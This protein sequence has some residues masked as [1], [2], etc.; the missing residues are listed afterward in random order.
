[1]PRIP[2]DRN[3]DLW[4]LALGRKMFGGQSNDT[5]AKIF[6]LNNGRRDQSTSTRPKHANRQDHLSG[7]EPKKVTPYPGK[8]SDLPIRQFVQFSLVPDRQTG[9]GDID[10][11]IVHGRLVDQRLQKVVH[12]AALWLAGFWPV[13]TVQDPDP[14]P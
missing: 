5:H 6:A 8:D 2:P 11:N 10:N 3:M 1:M 9:P 14:L 13:L 4:P 7:D 12:G